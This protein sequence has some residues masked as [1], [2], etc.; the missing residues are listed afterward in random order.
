[1][2]KTIGTDVSFWQ[3]DPNTTHVIDFKR[4]LQGGAKFVIIRA[5]QNRWEDNEF[6]IS[7]ANAKQAGIP[8]GSYWFYDSR[9]SPKEQA[10][11]WMKIMNGDL[12]ELPLWC[13][14]EDRY[15][16]AFGGWKHFYDFME[17]VKSLAPNKEIGVYTN[18]YYWLE[19]TIASP[20]G[21][22]NASLNYFKQY[23]L[24]VAAYNNVGPNVPAPWD[25]WTFWQFTDNGDGDLYGVESGNIDLNYFNGDEETLR[26]RFGLGAG[27]QPPPSVEAVQVSAMYQGKEVNYKEII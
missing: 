11:L 8:R 22:S 14:F 26:A 12:G 1:M 23:P 25:D 17:A 10:E 2:T 13:D 15:G 20:A 6:K 21:I 18:Y 3:D 16:G 7:W 5:G 24:W 9:V 27:N 19:H 4:M